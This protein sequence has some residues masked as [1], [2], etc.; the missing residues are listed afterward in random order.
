MA[1]SYHIKKICQSGYFHLRNISRIRHSLTDDAK[2]T[3]VHSLI[4]SRLDYCNALL[5]GVPACLIQKLQLL[6][7]SA[8]RLI[9]G[10][11]RSEHITPIL[12]QL[13]WLPVCQRIRYKI[14]L[15][16]YKALNSQAPDYIY[17]LLDGIDRSESSRTGVLKRAKVKCV[18]FGGRSFM[19]QA[20]NLWNELPQDIR[21]C[22]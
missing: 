19:A 10:T 20:P 1:M 13:H 6:Q 7:N 2:K 21:N 9:T 14:I 12:Y 16:T 18:T 3:L 15:L 5:G 17:D 11:R 4:S 22:Q 8:A